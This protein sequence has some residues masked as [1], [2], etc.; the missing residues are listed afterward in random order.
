MEAR[1]R[2]T[3]TVYRDEAAALMAAAARQG[4]VAAPGRQTAAP[5]GRR[6]AAPLVMPESRRPLP[7]PDPVGVN[8]N[9]DEP[10]PHYRRRLSV[11]RLLA[12]IVIAPL[13]L[14]VAL[15]AV[16]VIVLFTRSFLG[17]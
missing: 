9:L 10:D 16:A 4:V 17:L 6:K 11:P 12:R 14:A 8:D 5:S 7:Y 13:Y 15:A 2:T 1:T 3:D